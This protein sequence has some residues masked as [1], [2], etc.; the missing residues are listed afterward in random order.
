MGARGGASKQRA[1]KKIPD[2][3]CIGRADWLPAKKTHV[4]QQ[5]QKL[6]KS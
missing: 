5:V 1:A 6:G 4:L 2:T 3:F